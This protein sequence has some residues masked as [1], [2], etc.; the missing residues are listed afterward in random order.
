MS[1]SDYA[2]VVAIYDDDIGDDEYDGLRGI[3]TWATPADL[4]LTF[5]AHELGHLFG[6]Q[7]S[8]DESD[9]TVPGT[10]TQGYYWD[11]YDIMNARHVFSHSHPRWDVAGPNMHC[12]NRDY[13]GW[14]PASRI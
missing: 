14:I 12:A 7:D 10:T 4:Q 5:F 2:T 8:Y 3:L 6:V 9:R 1:R 11:Q 13:I